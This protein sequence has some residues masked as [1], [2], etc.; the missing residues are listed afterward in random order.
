MWSWDFYI[1]QQK[2]RIKTIVIPYFIMNTIQILLA[3]SKGLLL[4]KIGIGDCGEAD[5]SVITDN[6]F[7]DHYINPIDYPL[8]YLRDLI[9]MTFFSFVFYYLFRYL[10]LWGG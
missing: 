5:L 10:K 8:W 7:F 9:V 1:K 2:N 4:R 3:L 6:S